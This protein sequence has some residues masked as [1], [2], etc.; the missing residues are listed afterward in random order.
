MLASNIE[1]ALIAVIPFE[2]VGRLSEL[3]ILSL[4]ARRHLQDA[5][6]EENSDPVVIAAAKKLYLKRLR[7][8]LEFNKFL[9]GAYKIVLPPDYQGGGKVS[10][11]LLTRVEAA[12][13]GRNLRA[14]DGSGNVISP[15]ELAQYG[16]AV[17]DAFIN[18]DASGDRRFAGPGALRKRAALVDKL[19]ASLSIPDAWEAVTTDSTELEKIAKLEGRSERAAAY[20][21]YALNARPRHLEIRLKGGANRKHRLLF[22]ISGN[23]SSENPMLIPS[24]DEINAVLSGFTQMSELV[25][26]TNLSGR[27]SGVQ[28][29]T[30]R[31]NKNG[32]IEIRVGTHIP[33]ASK[34]A[35]EAKD[36]GTNGVANGAGRIYL[37]LGNIRTFA[38]PEKRRLV[39][40]YYAVDPESALDKL[41]GTTIHE[42]GHV[43]HYS[44]IDVPEF[45]R[46][47]RK[48]SVVTG[49]DEVTTT[50]ASSK[51]TE[52]FAESMVR[53]VKRGELSQ[54]LRQ[55]MIKKGLL[56]N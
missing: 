10:D 25:D 14:V 40:G 21:A 49:P 31:W 16:A 17:K 13:V 28:T 43:V 42:I 54:R 48:S 38:D 2:M 11:A 34:L 35:K 3:E 53:F 33:D 5:L 24:N 23:V 41:T 15:R 37:N 30:D 1:Q 27:N 18:A 44:I 22:E 56:L 20:A 9:E 7:D 8:Q 6:S 4:T 36:E 50:Y 46:L 55:L 12:E 26:L 32:V 45:D 29:M 47:Q 39:A 52:Q 51:A 19:A